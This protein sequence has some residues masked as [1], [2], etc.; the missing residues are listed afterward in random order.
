MAPDFQ[1]SNEVLTTIA[2]VLERLEIKLEKQEQRVNSLEDQAKR[3]SEHEHPVKEAERRIR[4]RS[5]SEK[6]TPVNLSLPSTI[7]Y[8]IWRL[9]LS[10]PHQ[11]LDLDFLKVIENQVG[12]YWKIPDDG[13]LPLKSFN[14]TIAS[15]DDGEDQSKSYSR[16]KR[17]IEKDSREVRQFDNA[18]R[19]Q[20]GNDFL[21]VD[22]DLKNN[23]RLYRVGAKAIGSQLRVEYG[24]SQQGPW[25]R[26]M[27]YKST[28]RSY[29]G[30]D[31]ESD[32]IRV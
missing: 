18:L 15:Q 21:V 3:V 11:I 17:Q 9:G 32:Y 5:L 26:I 1:P 28:D 24:H 4:T 7:P 8:S 29:I 25:S 30:T 13:R 2:Q 20:P 6:S 10:Q 27:Y 19:I 14:I 31:L 22:H 16:T 12:D 23:V